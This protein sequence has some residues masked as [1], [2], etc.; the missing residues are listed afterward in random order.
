MTT[1]ERVAAIIVSN[2]ILADESGN[3]EPNLL[4]YEI[5]RV[6]TAAVYTA[7]AA[8]NVTCKSAIVQIEKLLKESHR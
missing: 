6:A 1:L 5:A 7:G 4:I 8:G 2:K 3:R